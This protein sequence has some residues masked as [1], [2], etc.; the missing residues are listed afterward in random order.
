[1]DSMT[2]LTLS[3]P[4]TLAAIYLVPVAAPLRD[5]ATLVRREI[6]RRVGEPLR[7]LIL[8]AL[9]R[10]Q[11]RVE[12]WWAHDVALPSPDI[13]AAMGA[14]ASLLPAVRHALRF[15]VVSVVGV[16]GAPPLHEWAGRAIAATVAGAIGGP[17]VDVFTPRLMGADEAAG[18]LPTGDRSPPLAG[19][20]FVP[21]SPTGGGYRATTRGLGRFGL[22]ELQTRVVPG[23]L[24][25]PW[26]RVLTGI[27][28]RLLDAWHERLR[29]WDDAP[30]AFLELPAE[31]DVTA[32]AV[33]EAYGGTPTAEVEPGRADPGRAAGGIGLVL[34]PIGPDRETFLTVVPPEG[35]AGT[36]DEHLAAVCAATGTTA[37]AAGPRGVP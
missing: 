11:A 34:D 23:E 32:A 17:V 24:M 36:P 33:A 5:P 21:Y 3:V 16:P 13:F 26:C 2:T 10:G 27:A 1:M 25:V 14:P 12:V 30:A 15:V 35:F 7:H 19:W 28:S 9:G 18:S 31:L 37:V 8:D 6:E 20:L 4:R 29:T 22:P